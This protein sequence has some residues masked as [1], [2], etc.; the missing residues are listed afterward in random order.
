MK[1]KTTKQ[2]SPK[3]R[4]PIKGRKRQYRIRNWSEYNAALVRRGSLTV[5]LDEG[6]ASSWLEQ[7]VSGQRGASR[8]YSDGA[9]EIA[10]T[11]KAVYRLTLRATEGLMTSLL[12]LAG[13]YELPVPDYS[14]LCRRQKTLPV[15]IDEQKERTAAIHLVVDST[16]CKVYGEGEWKVRQ[17]G[18]GKRRTWLKL[19]LGINENNGEIRTAVLTDN[20]VGDAETLPDLLEQVEEPLSQVSGDGIYDTLG[21]YRALE[22]RSQE[23][24]QDLKVTIPPRHTARIL[25]HGNK[26]GARHARD[27]NLRCTRK[28]GRKAWKEESGYH[29]RSLAETT[30][31][32][33]K[34]QFG[35]RLSARNFKSQATEVFLRCRILNIMNALGKPVSVCLSP[36]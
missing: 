25:H 23:Q 21:C 28:I 1:K 11:L 17:H 10:L 20:S 3:R 12:S 6:A 36:T 30:M 14:T 19:H 4:R 24:G 22:K 13:L 8:F 26:N 32:R 16:G 33:L 18:Y 27:E 35:E 7:Q 31:F 29:R 5:W 34:Q 2:R 15:V 9:I